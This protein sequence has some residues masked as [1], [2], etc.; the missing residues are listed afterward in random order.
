MAYRH[1][2]R[3]NRRRSQVVWESVLKPQWVALWFPCLVVAEVVE[4]EGRSRSLS[5]NMCLVLDVAQTL[6][7]TLSGQQQLALSTF[8]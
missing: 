6:G 4:E 3:D 7:G 1:R 2:D 8:S 5:H